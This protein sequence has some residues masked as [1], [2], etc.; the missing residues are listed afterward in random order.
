MTT[1]ANETKA[2][3]YSFNSAIPVP[4][5]ARTMG[6]PRYAHLAWR[7]MEIA[8]RVTVPAKAI[9]FS[10]IEMPAQ[11]KHNIGS[12]EIL[13][14]ASLDDGEIQVCL[15]RDD[16]AKLQD[17]LLEVDYDRDAVEGKV[18]VTISLPPPVAVVYKRINLPRVTMGELC[19]NA[20]VFMEVDNVAGV[21]EPQQNKPR[22]NQRRTRYAGKDRTLN[23]RL[24]A[25]HAYWFNYWVN[26]KV[27][28]DEPDAPVEEYKDT[29]FWPATRRLG[30]HANDWMQ[31]SERDLVHEDDQGNLVESDPVLQGSHGNLLQSVAEERFRVYLVPEFASTAGGRGSRTLYLQDL[32]MLVHAMDSG[33]IAKMLTANDIFLPRADMPNDFFC[34][35]GVNDP[36][37]N[38]TVVTQVAFGY[39]VSLYKTRRT[40]GRR[41]F[42]TD[43]DGNKIVNNDRGALVIIG[44]K[45]AH[46]AV[47]ALYA[48]FVNGGMDRFYEEHMLLIPE[49]AF[50]ADDEEARHAYHEKMRAQKAQ[51]TSEGGEREDTSSQEPPAPATTDETDGD[52]EVEFGDNSD[53]LPPP[54]ASEEEDDEGDEEEEEEEEEDAEDSDET[55][56]DAG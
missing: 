46:Q 45:T 47:G 54:A 1:D 37:N 34:C 27:N 18:V 56:S 5:K 12:I 52:G 19:S 31:R 24:Q 29:Y 55:E 8:V 13:M 4:E 53:K 33:K 11:R 38:N 3:G 44:A 41:E 10:L 49:E 15:P 40:E 36:I 39:T 30:V 17:K 35:L 42:I 9:E 48:E 22:G 16:M 28:P 23:H 50:L 14:D 26:R 2:F 51:S 25:M 6:I 21:F 20:V 32:Q 43:K 7:N